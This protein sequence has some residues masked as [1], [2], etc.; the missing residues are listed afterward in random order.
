MYKY[1]FAVVLTLAMVMVCGVAYAFDYGH[2]FGTLTPWPA[3]SECGYCHVDNSTPYGQRTGP[4][5]GYTATSNKCGLCHTLHDANSPYKLLPEFTVKATC[6][7]CHD[8]T[9]GSGVYGSIKA[10][11]LTVGAS[12]RVETSTVIP[13]GDGASGGSRTEVFKGTGGTLTC[14]DCHSPHNSKTVAGFR[15]ERVR[16]NSG[17]QNIGAPTKEWRT[18]KLLR[19]RPTGADTT[20]TVYGSDWCASCHMGR[21]SGATVHNHPVDSKVT[22]TSPFYY[23]NVAVVKSDTSLE[24]TYGTMGMEGTSTPNLYWH[25]RGFVMPYPRTAE[26]AGH[27]PICQQCHEDSRV[28]GEPGAVNRAQI[29]SYGNGVT[30]NETPNPSG[31]ASDSPLFQNFPHETQNARLL[32]EVDDNLCLN[33]HSMA[34]LP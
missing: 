1:A 13:G 24:T 3:F 29:Y 16:F 11:G 26:Q 23:D 4:H 9:A 33:C 31:P 18:S 7:M 32:V 17:E 28:V 30:L 6:E 15:G 8:G 20:S 2:G 25:N 14:G 19:Q 12:H 10:R 22:T 5:D 34:Q 21:S 27:S